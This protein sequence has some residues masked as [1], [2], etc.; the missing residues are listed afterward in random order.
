M[1]SNTGENSAR[2]SVGTSVPRIRRGKQKETDNMK[3][4]RPF[5][6]MPQVRIVQ[7]VLTTKGST[8]LNFARQTIT[9]YHMGVWGDGGGGEGV[10]GQLGG[11]LSKG[12]SDRRTVECH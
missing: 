3:D 11:N 2:F 5:E 8:G 12:G 10:P 6:L 1:V 4:S 9:S 7:P